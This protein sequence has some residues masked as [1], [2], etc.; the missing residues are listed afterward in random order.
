M[1]RPTKLELSGEGALR[2][3]WDDSGVREYTVRELRDACPCAT[4]RE[5][6]SAPPQPANAL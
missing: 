2:I 1:P 5:K 6:R 4:C 3:F